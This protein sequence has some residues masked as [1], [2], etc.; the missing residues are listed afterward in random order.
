MAEEIRTNV[1]SMGT[2]NGA[3]KRGK[4]AENREKMFF[5]GN[6]LSHLLQT[7]ELV[8]LEGKNELVFERKKGQTNVKKWPKTHLFARFERERGERGAT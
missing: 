1:L 7:Q 2:R 3:G 4:T 6:E 8:F 5:R